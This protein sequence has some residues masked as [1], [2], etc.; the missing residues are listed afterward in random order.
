MILLF[1]LDG[2]RNYYTAIYAI[3]ISILLT[4]GFLGAKFVIRRSFYSRIS[5]QPKKMEDALIRHTQGPEHIATAAYTRTL[6]K[7]YQN[8]VQTLYTSQ[9]RQLQFVNQ[10]VHQMKTPISVINLL[11]Q[12]DGELD[13]KSLAEE[14][15]RIQSG[16]DLVL[17]NARLETFERDMNIERVSLKKIV[18]EVVTEHKRLLITNGIFPVFLI[19]ESFII[20]TDIKWM[21]IVIAQFVTNAVK[22]TF[23]SGK[24]IYL[25][26]ECTGNGV[27]LTVR[28]EGVGIPTSDLNRV[29]NAFF[30]GENGRLTGE[31]TGMGLYI[32]SEVCGKLGHILKIDSE[33]GVG[34]TVTVLFENGKSEET[35][36]SEDNGGIAGSN[37]NL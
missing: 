24:K 29:T 31:S 37:E 23:E 9:N 34:T 30:T 14:V 17:V 5:V 10:W 1:W 33:L 6:Y 28:D 7:L 19:D 4:I 18:Q 20:A 25:T 27:L 26:A 8:E 35:N 15:S 2:F 21:K 36:D 3:I 22:Y 12:E 13:R 32:A 16:L 11:L